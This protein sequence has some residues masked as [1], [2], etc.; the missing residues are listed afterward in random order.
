MLLALVTQP[1]DADDEHDGP[2]EHPQVPEDQ[3]SEVHGVE[4]LVTAPRTHG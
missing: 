1:H 2:D 4:R 3:L